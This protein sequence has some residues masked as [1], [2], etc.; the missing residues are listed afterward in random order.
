MQSIVKKSLN[1]SD[2]IDWLYGMPVEAGV[3]PSKDTLPYAMPNFH[4]KRA[5]A[6]LTDEQSDFVYF[7][8]DPMAASIKIG[9]AKTLKSRQSVLMKDYGEYTFM[10]AY[11]LGNRSLEYKIHEE[12][13]DARYS[14]ESYY[15]GYTEWFWPCPDLIEILMW[16]TLIYSRWAT[17]KFLYDM[18]RYWGIPLLDPPIA[19]DLANLNGVAVAKPP[20]QRE[21]ELYEMT[22][23]VVRQSII[24][25]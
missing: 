3:S 23:Q 19:G 17:E 6:K 15:E 12:L 7:F 2:V 13:K 22:K 4:L 11:A 18:R 14:R 9:Y 8:A 24:Q 10:L 16:A 1:S 25:P 5:V 20:Y 21:M